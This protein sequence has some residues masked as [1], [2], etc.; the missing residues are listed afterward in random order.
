MNKR[1]KIQ[2]LLALLLF[3]S[4][5]CNKVEESPGFSS[6]KVDNDKI[7]SIKEFLS[8]SEDFSNRTVIVEGIIEHLCRHSEKRFKIINPEGN[9]ELKVETCENLDRPEQSDIG[10]KIKIKAKVIPEQMDMEA[11]S[12]WEDSIRK[13]HAGEEE[14]DHFKE[15]IAI[16]Q[17]AK[18]KI[19]SG[20]ITYYITY[21][22][23]AI[24]Y[25][26]SDK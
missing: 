17:Q 4:A 12:N 16:V 19:I 9:Y 24:A 5:A 15:E 14:T 26:F 8:L 13:N 1:L 20:Q 2:F 3:V 22:A 18:D 6:I 7:L 25:E 21:K 23:E 10:K 11:L